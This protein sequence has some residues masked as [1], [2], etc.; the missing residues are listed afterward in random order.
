MSIVPP[1]NP[2]K[3]YVEQYLTPLAGEITGW[4]AGLGKTLDDVRWWEVTGSRKST[5]LFVWKLHIAVIFSS[6]DVKHEKMFTWRPSVQE[7]L[8]GK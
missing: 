3:P 8:E 7:M 5:E 6:S 1:I 2:F 4:L